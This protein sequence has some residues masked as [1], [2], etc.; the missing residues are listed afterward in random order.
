[1]MSQMPH[2]AATSAMPPRP[3]KNANTRTRPRPEL[4]MPTSKVIALRLRSGSPV[5]RAMP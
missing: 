4:R 3:S 1:M 5:A 2:Q